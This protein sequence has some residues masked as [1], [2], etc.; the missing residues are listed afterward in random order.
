MASFVYLC[1]C[2]FLP[3]DFVA[4]SPADAQMHTEHHDL[5]VSI[6]LIYLLYLTEDLAKKQD[7][8]GEAVQG[9]PWHG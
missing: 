5:Q 8:H 4:T 6:V 7:D 9:I 2:L 3:R 1:I